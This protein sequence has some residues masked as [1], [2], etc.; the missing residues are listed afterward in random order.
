[1]ASG[2]WYV[3][4]DLVNALF[5]ISIFKNVEEKQF[6]FTWNRQEYTCHKIV[7]RALDWLDI[8]QNTIL[9]YNINDIIWDYSIWSERIAKKLLVQRKHYKIREC[10]RIGGNNSTKNQ[11]PTTSINVFGVQWYREYW[12]IYFK[13]NNKLLYPVPPTTKEGIN[14]WGP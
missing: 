1:M 8:I 5:Y 7:W 10:Q 6:E 13:V 2:T 4:I 3:A 11:E 12:A 14:F 9:V